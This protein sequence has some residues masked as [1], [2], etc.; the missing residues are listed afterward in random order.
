MVTREEL[1]NF[2]DLLPDGIVAASG[3]VFPNIGIPLTAET[4][5]PQRSAEVL[6]ETPRILRLCG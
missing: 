3:Q 2:I 1:H 4:Q 5:S 6:W